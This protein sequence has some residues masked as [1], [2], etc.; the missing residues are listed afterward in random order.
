MTDKA[1]EIQLPA[2]FKSNLPEPT[3]VQEKLKAT[4]GTMYTK[5]EAELNDAVDDV[6]TKAGREA[7]ASRSYKISRTK[8][9]LEKA[10]KELT[11]EQNA[12]VKVVTTERLEMC[13]TMD[14]LRDRSR[15]PLNKWEAQEVARVAGLKA[16]LE[17]L[18]DLGRVD[19]MTAPDQIRKMIEELTITFTS[20]DWAEYQAAAEAAHNLAVEKFT[21]DLIASEKRIADEAELAEL[22]AKAAEQQ[23]KEEAARL[24]QAAREQAE[25]AEQQEKARQQAAKEQADRDAAELVKAEKARAEQAEARAKQAEADAIAAAE[26]AEADKIAAAEQAEAIKVRAEEFARNEE[27]NRLARIAEGEKEAEEARAADLQHRK[28]IN[29]GALEAL[30]KCSEISQEQAKMIIEAMVKNQIPHVKIS[31]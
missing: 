29:N 24:E 7:I 6:T 5:I 27:R 4:F 3:E 18:Q 12:I 8:T 2:I 21:A 10:A 19:A 13:S 14:A 16:A 22:R 31:Y 25:H 26:K 9:G 15:E 28:K 1:T 11:A 17:Y 30:I 23:R 20:E